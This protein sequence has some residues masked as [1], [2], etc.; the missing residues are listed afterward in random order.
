[1]E[2]TVDTPYGRLAGGV[3]DG[4]H[5]FLGISYAAPP[6]GPNRLR[7]PRPPAPWS[8]VRAARRIGPASLQTLAGAQTWLND[9]IDRQDEDCLTLNVWVPADADHAPILVWFHGGATRNGHGGMAAIDGETLARRHGIMVVTVNY[10]L[11]ALGGLAHPDLVDEVT[12]HCANW[13]MQDKIAA[14]EWVRACGAAF[15]GDTASVTIAGQS[16]GATNVVL[17]AQNPACRHLF[18]R[19]IAQSPPLFREPMFA[20]LAGAAEYAEALAAE[21]GTTVSGLRALDGPVLMARE[22]AFLRQS[23]LAHRFG[24]PRTAPTLDGRLVA[25]W[26]HDGR[27]A[28]VPLLIGFTADEALFWYDLKLPDGTALTTL[29]PPADESRLAAEIERLIALHYS[30]LGPPDAEAVV[31]RY[32]E[33]ADGGSDLRGLWLAIYTDLVFRA[34]ILRY[35]LRHAE[36]APAYVYE[37]AWPLAAPVFGAPHAADVPFVFGTTGHPHLG[38]KIGEG[39]TA[40]SEAMMALWAGFVRSGVPSAEGLPLWEPLV[41][42]GALAAMV[43]GARK[44]PA[45]FGP[46]PRP[47]PLRAW[48]ALLPSLPIEP[49]PS[50]TRLA[51]GA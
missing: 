18:A 49:R 39:S 43:I 10:R 35:A 13:G 28:A 51:D 48:P 25:A 2:A 47:G 8:G 20:D 16:S 24:R 36:R 37:F 30:F 34:P 22:A 4:V 29:I 44:V 7:S 46:L 33:G 9:P 23:P 42:A 14:L 19:V 5:R 12:G 31:R 45:C 50:R 21:C 11:G 17:I 1:M 40:T 15:G 38:P 26:P 6:T 27:A 41:P 3:L 32:R